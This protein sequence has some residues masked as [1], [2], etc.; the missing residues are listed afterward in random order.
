V[1]RAQ[2]DTI[3]DRLADAID[4]ALAASTSHRRTG[5]AADGPR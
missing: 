2:I 4:A 1:N 3:V 5:G